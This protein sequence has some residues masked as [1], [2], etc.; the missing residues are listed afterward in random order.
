MRCVYVSLIFPWTCA[1][2]LLCHNNNKMMILVLLV[3]C[4]TVVFV[5][6]ASKCT[7]VFLLKRKDDIH[8][9]AQKMSDT[10]MNDI[11]VPNTK[12]HFSFSSK[13]QWCDYFWAFKIS[14]FNHRHR[15]RHHRH[16]HSRTQRSRIEFKFWFYQITDKRKIDN[17]YWQLDSA[18]SLSLLFASISSQTYTM[19]NRQIICNRKKTPEKSRKW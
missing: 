10:I 9:H 7:A 15:R 5:S 19:I 1:S 6:V 18:T 16:T 14:D 4:I 8:I 17:N 2:L 12:F 11:H 3:V 13:F